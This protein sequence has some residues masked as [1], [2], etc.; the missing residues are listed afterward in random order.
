MSPIS[1]KVLIEILILAV[2]GLLYLAFR[3][4]QSAILRY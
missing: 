1:R 2:I 4:Y 3:A